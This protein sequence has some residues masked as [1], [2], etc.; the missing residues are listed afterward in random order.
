MTVTNAVRRSLA[1]IALGAPARVFPIVGPDAPASLDYL[2]LASGITL[3]DSPR[4]ANVLLVAGSLP[5]ALHE[6][7]AP[8]QPD[9]ASLFA[10][11]LPVGPLDDLPSALRRLQQEL[12]TAGLGSHYPTRRSTSGPDPIGDVGR[13]DPACVRFR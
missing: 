11:A 2:R 3:L 1:R 10:G 5:E 12:V 13:I 9:G 4:S 7:G 6:T 8:G